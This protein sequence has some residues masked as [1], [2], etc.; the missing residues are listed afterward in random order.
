MEKNTIM[1][2]VCFE[3]RLETDTFISLWEPYAKQLL[4]DSGDIVLQ[5]ALAEKNRNRFKYMSQHECNRSDFQFAFMKGRVHFR[6]NK[7]KIIQAGGYI[8]VQVQCQHN[9]VKGDVKVIAFLAANDTD[10][11]FYHRQTYRHLNIYEAYFENCAYSYIL[12][13]FIQ[14]PEA[15]ALVDQLR[16]RR[17]VEVALFKE[18]ALVPS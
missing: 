3:T 13:F 6:D 10:M 4:R 16:S 14:E 12:E 17:G 18:L 7:A 11:E 9:D 1:Q 2:F 15:P 5:E 8:P